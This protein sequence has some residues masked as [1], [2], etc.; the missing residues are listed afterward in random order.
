MQNTGVRGYVKG[1]DG[2]RAVAVIA[3]ILYHMD[4]L[5]VLKGSFTGVDIFFVISGYVISRSIYN[6]KFSKLSDYLSEFYKRRLLRILPAL[7]I[8][9][10][11]T[12]LLS[13]LFIPEAWLSR[14]IDKTGLSAFWGYSN[15]SLT[16][17][18][19]SYFSPGAEYNPFLH[20]WSLAVEEQFY[21]LFPLIFFVW[22]KYRDRK[23]GAGLISRILL[24]VTGLMS[25]IYVIFATSSN[26]ESAFYLLPGRFWELA[27]GAFLFMLHERKKLILKSKI[28]S[29]LFMAGGLLLALAGFIFSVER[30]FPFPWAI[31]PVFAAVLIITSIVSSEKRPSFIH[32]FFSSKPVVYIGKIS[33][34]LYL[35]H[36]PFA[37]LLRWTTGI[38]NYWI[39]LMYLTA[40]FAV[41]SVSYIFLENPVRKNK[42]LLKQKNWKIITGGIAAIVVMFS[43]ALAIINNKSS[44][45]L[46]VTSNSYIWRAR[47]H[48]QDRPTKPVVPAPDIAGRKIFIMGDSHTAAYRTMMNI[49]ASH[50]G[51]EVYEYEE[52]GCA[53]AGLLEPMSGLDGCKSFFEDSIHEVKELAKPGDIVFL[54]SLRMPELS[55]IDNTNE[56]LEKNRSREA[57]KKREQ[58]LEEA[59]LLIKEFDTLGLFVI[60][61]APLPVLKVAPY[62]CSDWFN[63]MNP[64]CEPGL[65]VSRNLLL[66]LRQP[67]VDSQNTIQKRHKNLYIWD[68]FT[69]L[70][71]EEKFSAYDENGFPIFFDGDH[72]SGNGNRILT[73]SFMEKV[74]SIW[75]INIPE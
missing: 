43:G 71:K 12:V 2:L 28:T 19:D 47:R 6:R 69:I 49:V 72:L 65:T 66:E 3:V 54:A 59:S 32:S 35:W 53:I 63:R 31:V 56:V 40:V 5:H 52:G 26:H 10:G 75:K 60:M 61:E 62:R 17:N 74:L 14:T 4:F 21:L 9:L 68:P 64:A 37:V 13:T 41:A 67:V 45:S 20:T 15:F 36:W 57:V 73:P 51:I 7:L 42:F 27:C 29:N 24:I 33:Y 18:N 50:L 39:I 8:C 22:L 55:G 25:F 38:Q 46:S 11:I 44:I 34:S 16:W 58:A 70:C 30:D 1:I 23:S 48:W